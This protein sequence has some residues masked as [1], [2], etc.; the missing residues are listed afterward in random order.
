MVMGIAGDIAGDGVRGKLS[1]S[2]SGDC[3]SS[4]EIFIA[5]TIESCS[6][7]SFRVTGV[8]G[9]LRGFDEDNWE[10]NT[11]DAD[12]I[13]SIAGVGVGETISMSARSNGGVSFSNSG[14]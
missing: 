2:E 13:S 8:R 4:S 1:L 5:S 7:S 14:S 12:R 6:S 10:S 3:A 9:G 11:G